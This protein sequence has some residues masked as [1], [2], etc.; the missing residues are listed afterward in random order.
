MKKK[1]TIELKMFMKFRKYLPADSSDGKAM[2]SLEE[3]STL[4]GLLKI[5]GVPDDEHGIVVINGI[6]QGMDSPQVLK[7]G[8]VVAFFAPVGGG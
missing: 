1:V 2:I 5:L 3:G 6:S 7:D 4:E 8:D